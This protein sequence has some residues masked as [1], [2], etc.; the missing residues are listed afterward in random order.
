MFF[1]LK[2]GYLANA[3]F[4][5]KHNIFCSDFDC[6]ANAKVDS[7]YILKN[8]VFRPKF[9]HLKHDIKDKK[10][11]SQLEAFHKKILVKSKVI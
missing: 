5:S 11:R 2:F 1:S 9:D 10:L 6:L 3:I 7:K 4:D 8:E